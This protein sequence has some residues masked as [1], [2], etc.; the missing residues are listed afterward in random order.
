[1]K[2]IFIFALLLMSA[3]MAAQCHPDSTAT[4]SVQL[5]STTMNPHPNVPTYKNM[6][7]ETKCVESKTYYRYLVPCEDIQH[8]QD[9][10]N[11]VKARY[12]DA[13]IVIYHHKKRY[14]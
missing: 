13:F 14:N 3:V 7:V 8:A 11:D 6:Y 1:M 10:L 12:K 2:H 4:Y 5:F 9:T